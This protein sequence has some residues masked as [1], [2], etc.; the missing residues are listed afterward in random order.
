MDNFDDVLGA[1]QAEGEML[2]D[3]GTNGPLEGLRAV[4][5]ANSTKRSHREQ[6]AGETLTRM[7]AGIGQVGDGTGR[8]AVQVGAQG[9]DDPGR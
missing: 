4:R 1:L 9:G 5:H 7:G 6:G 8:L 2:L 3:A